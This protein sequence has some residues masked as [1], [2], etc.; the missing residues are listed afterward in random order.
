MWHDTKETYDDEVV[1][2]DKDRVIST[3]C[4]CSHNPRVLI[5][6]RSKNYM[7][8][9]VRLLCFCV[10]YT[11]LSFTHSCEGRNGKEPIRKIKTAQVNRYA[12]FTKLDAGCSAVV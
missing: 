11:L 1:T 12:R 6:K 10:Y 3:A 2:C 7:A 5:Y 9:R 4:C 8:N